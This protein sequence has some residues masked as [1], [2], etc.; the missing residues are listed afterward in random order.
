MSTK[1]CALL[2]TGHGRGTTEART[3]AT[4]RSVRTLQVTV[5]DVKAPQDVETREDLRHV[6]LDL[7]DVRH[8]LRVD[9]A[10]EIVLGALEHERHLAHAAVRLCTSR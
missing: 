7:R 6:A 9:E 1:R 2:G 3:Q 4:T 5:Q 10:A 8:H